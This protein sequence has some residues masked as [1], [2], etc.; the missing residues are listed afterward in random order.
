[1]DKRYKHLIIVILTSLLATSAFF[2]CL[3]RPAKSNPGVI[4][5]DRNAPGP[6]HDGST[7]EKGHTTLQAALDDAENPDQIWVAQGIYTPTK[8]VIAGL[9]RSSTFQLTSGVSLYGGFPT[10]GGDGSFDARDVDTYATILSGDLGIIGDDSD[11]SFHVVTSSGNDKTTILDGF[12]ISGGKANG[13]LEYDRGGGMHN[14]NSNATI[15]NITFQGN[16]AIYGGGMYNTNSSPSLSSVTFYTNTASYGGGLANSNSDPTLSK[17][18]FTHNHAVTQGGGLH[19]DSDSAPDLTECIFEDNTTDDNGGGLYN[20]SS[21]LTLTKVSFTDN[22]ATDWGGGMYNDDASPVLKELTFQHNKADQGGGMYNHSSDPQLTNASFLGNKA[23]YGGGMYN[24][25]SSPQVTN[26]IFSGNYTAGSFQMGGGMYNRDSSP[27][28]INLTFSGNQANTGGGIRNIN[29]SNPTLINVILWGNTAPTGPQ[30]VNNNYS[31]PSIRYSLIQGCGASGAGWDDNL[32][33][34]G[35]HNLDTNP[36]FRRNP[37]PGIDGNWGTADDDYG[38]LRLDLS[39]PAIDAGDNTGVPGGVLTDLA[40]KPRFVDIEEIADTGYG[41]PPIVDLGAYEARFGVEITK[42]VNIQSP[43]EGQVITYM[44][45]VENTGT[46]TVANGIISD[47]LPG[48]LTF[49]GPVEITPSQAGKPGTTPPLLAYDLTIGANETVTITFPVSLAD[50]PA[51]LLNQATISSPDLSEPVSD[52]VS[53][54]VE[55]VPPTIA[56]QGGESIVEGSTYTLTLGAITDPGNDTVT[57]QHVHWGDDHTD[58]Y[59]TTGDITHTYKDG[60]AN[61]TITV[62]LVDEDGTHIAAGTRQITVTN[63]IP[64]VAAG[65]DISLTAGETLTRSGTFQ[66]PGADQW[67]ATV[68]YGEGDGPKTLVL[69]GKAFRLV[70]PF[71]NSGVYTVT[72]TI[73]DDDGGGGYD[74][75]TVTVLDI[76]EIHYWL[77]L[78]F[79]IRKIPVLPPG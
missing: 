28:L 36:L 67:T 2:L 75:F 19:N 55:N 12:T 8:R 21:D 68:D 65:E 77:Y 56:L 40:G 1:M 59:A 10:G 24:Y 79:L 42:T 11:N 50:G 38:D 26:A 5:V 7:W 49:I 52:T 15:K 4:Y 45:I 31:T 25:E 63:A 39:S 43:L 76:P 14:N 22:E 9:P 71:L 61:H 33:D 70:H 64:I 3:T 58:I 32:G 60:D 13:G 48:D 78:P 44:I 57:H 74:S 69:E 30:M 23:D 54:V 29:F 27:T 35:G 18:T 34:D 53:I 6:T 17:V 66:D 51:S 37:T 46:I 47:D 20:R 73:N 72:V 62:D 41:S 16:N